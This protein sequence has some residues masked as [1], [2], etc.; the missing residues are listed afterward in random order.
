MGGTPTITDSFYFPR[1]LNDEWKRDGYSEVYA[2]YENEK[3][4]V[5]SVPSS[6]KDNSTLLFKHEITL[7]SR[8]EI[9]DN[10]LFFDAVSKD[11]DMF[12][13]D[14][15]RSNQTSFSFSG[16]I[17]EFVDRINSS[18]AY[19]GVYNP[20]AKEENSKGYH[21][22]IVE[23]YGTDDIKELSF[24]DQYITDV[25]QEIYNTFGLTYYWKGNTCYV[26]KCEN[27]L[28]DENNVIKYG[29]N[30]ALI[31]VNEENTNNK[32][33]DMVT[34]YGSSDNIP[35]YYPNDDEF[36]KAI[37]KTSL[38][39][40]SQVTIALSKLQ[41]NVGGDYAKTYQF[42]KRI[43]DTTG[44]IPITQLNTPFSGASG[45]LVV[46]SGES[47][48]RIKTFVISAKAGTKIHEAEIKT[49]HTTTDNV[50]IKSDTFESYIEVLKKTDNKYEGSRTDWNGKYNGVYECI[51]A[52]LYHVTLRETITVVSKTGKSIS[53]DD[54]INYSYQG[55]LKVD[56]QN[57][58]EYYW[59]YDKGIVEYEDGGIEVI[60]PSTTP[61]AKSVVTFAPKNDP[62]V[63]VYTYYEFSEAIDTTTEAEAAK[64]YI[65]G[66]EWI[67]PTDKLMPSV[68]RNTGGAQR[69]YFATEN[70]SEE[71][72]DIYLNPN[73]NKQYEFKN[74]YKED[75]PHQ[76][77][78]SFEDIKPTIRDIRNDV[79]QADGLGQ[80]FGEIA[81]VAFDS[82]DSDVKDGDGNYIHQY[83]YIKLHK[84]SG[85]F[86]FNLFSSAFEEGAKIE[87]IDC[88]GCPAC[89]FPIKVVWVAAK[90]KCYNCVSVDKDGNLKSLRTE[91]NDYILSD[92]EA[93]L[94]T[95]NQ[96]TMLSEVWIAVQKD[97]STLGIVMPNVNGNF[98][99]KRGDK[100]VITGINSPKVLTL[101][102]EKKLDKAL[103]KYMSE[104][105]EDKFNYSVKFSRIYLAEHPNF[106][107]KLN[108]NAKV[109]LEYNGVRH[110][111]FVNNYSVK[112]DGKIL[113]EVNVELTESVEP[114]Q[115]DIK[116]IV[117]S[118]KNSISFGSP[119]GSNKF[120]ASTTDKLY[121]SK[122]KDDTA[123]GLITFLK[124]LKSQ[125]VIKAINGVSLGNGESHING[126]GDAKLTDVVVD[127]IHDKNSTPSDRVIIG[128]QGFDLYLGDDG[129]SH[130]YV[131]YLTARTRMFASSVEIRK[132][133]Y[134]GGTTIFS[135]AGS[136]IA[137]VS[138]IW[139]AAKEKVIAYKCYA[140]AD[141]GTT[142]TMNWWHVGMMALCQTFNVKAG[143]SEDF[144]NRYYWRMVVGVGQEKIDGKIYDYVILSNVKEFQGNLLTVPSF[145]DKTLANEQSKKLVWGDVMVEITMDKGMQ[146]LASLFM[147]QE[148]T[149]VDDNGN[150]IADR[151]F[152]GYDGE[153]PDAPA[154]FDVIVQVGDQIQWKKYG[155]VIKLSTSTEDNATDNAPAITMYHK[156]GAPH[157]TGSLDANGNK[158]V[159][160]YQWKIITTIISPEKVMHNTD[161]FQLFQG[162]PDNII[163]PITIM[164]DIVPSVAYYTR[165]PST[166]TTTPT[167]ITFSLRKRTGNKV[168]TLTDAQIYA[169]YTLLNGSSATKLL[170]NKALS[171]IGNL[172]QITSVKL[173]STIKEADHEDIVVIY[174]LPVLT[175]GVKGD[176][177]AAGK[178]GTNGRDGVDGKDGINGT[179]GK[180][181]VDGKDGKTPAVVS[182][183]YQYAIT[184]TSAKPADSEWKPVMPDPSKYE[185]KF[186]WT[187][188]TT[189]WSTGDKTDT[190]SCTYIGTDGADGT[191]VT[192][193]GTLGSISELPST[194]TA[195]DGYIIGVFLWIYTGTTTEDSNNHNGYTNV[196]KIKGEDG[197]N[198]TQYYIH[199][200]WMKASDG[201]GFTV[202]NPNGDAYPYV[203]TLV[204]ANEKDS[205]NWRDYKWTYVKGDTGAKGDKGDKGD[206]GLPGVDGAP[207][208]NGKD[209]EDAINIVVKD[210]PMVFDTEDN[211]L[212][213]DGA[214]RYASIFVYHKKENISSQLENVAVYS[215]ENCEC[216]VAYNSVRNCLRAKVYKVAKEDITVDGATTQISKTAGYAT[217]RF[218][219]NGVMYYQQVQFV[220]NVSKFN[221]SVIQTT[222]KYEQKYTEVSNQIDTLSTDVNNLDSNLG[223]LRDNVDSLDQ[224]VAAI[225]LRSAQDLTTFE[226]KI[227][228]TAR[229]ISLSLTEQAVSRRNLLVNSD[230]A[231]NGGFALS[232]PSK[233]TVERLSGYE[234]S[235]CI[236]TFTS[237]TSFPALRWEGYTAKT[238]NIPI[239]GGKKYTISCWVKVS[240]TNAPLYVKVF[241]QKA[242]TGNVE[243]TTAA[244][245]TILDK[246]VPLNS[247]NTWQLVSFT[248]VASGG[249]SYCSVRLFF[250]PPST[251]LIDGYICRPMLEQSDSYNGWTLSE[252]DYNYQ[253]GNMLDNTRY[254]NTGGNLTQV[255]L[256]I[257]NAKDGCSLSEATVQQN[258]SATLVRFDNVS[259]AANTDYVLS[260]F[261]RS[262]FLS[263]KTNV[264]C[265]LNLVTN[266]KFAECSSGSV[267]SYTSANGN[268]TT[269]GYIEL[270][271]IPTEW[272]KVWYH[273]S[274][275]NTVTNQAIAIQMYGRN[276]A[277]TLQVCQ[278]KLEAG[279]MN[280][281]WT[282]ATEDV[283]NK[284]A[285]KRTGI[286]IESGKITL[287]AENTVITGDLHLRGILVENY[288]DLSA[289]NDLF[290]VCDMKAHKSVTVSHS[291]VILPMLDT[292]TIKDHNDKEYTVNG[293]KEAGVKLTIASKYNSY[294]AKW[295]Q[296][297]P[298][299][300]ESYKNFDNRGLMKTY[301]NYASVVFADPRIADKGNYKI[302]SGID[303]LV[304]TILPEGGGGYA[305]TGYEGGVFVCNGRRGRA[306]VLMPG[307]TLH[308][309]SAIE[310]VNEKQVLVWYVD[311]SSDF[312]PLTKEICFYSWD[313]YTY[314]HG[315]RSNGGNAFPMEVSGSSGSEYEDA[316]FG[317]KILDET[318]LNGSLHAYWGG[319][320]TG[321]SD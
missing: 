252:E 320:L 51:E 176:Q 226:S 29:V 106:A 112:R 267:S 142:K 35:F 189:T 69:F 86:G 55:S 8:R 212:V 160:P 158:I 22:E 311:N 155:N 277:G 111:L 113:A 172:Y 60:A 90:N 61:F 263:S 63:T 254:L 309:T 33:I 203:G 197:K 270:G 294:V 295:A 198:A 99:P 74:K 187:K 233:A 154:P 136:Q 306:L 219:Y 206:Q 144:A 181:G 53:V 71:Y 256:L 209:G 265:T 284:D 202:A 149:D 177:G 312:T 49:A 182:T 166:Q 301:H 227:T 163:D 14:K 45:S 214:V 37:Y 138:Y 307:Q 232:T 17:Y 134:S 41:K 64:V 184:A 164:Y 30:D 44:I 34:G 246:V 273:F 257:G 115:N 52:G 116:Q 148:G 319:F 218:S 286:D 292:H 229:N 321:Y 260:F 223:N 175:D 249:Y 82:T 248:F 275:H 20:K 302:V 130:L 191:S 242:I 126:N 205:T 207:G 194:G 220:V 50:T 31:S 24:S 297:T 120:N 235:N 68:Y 66:R 228:Q 308:L 27:D 179:N 241:G 70:P 2:E 317:T 95:L 38:I 161:N 15:Y 42:C 271:N 110:E 19:I 244:T 313:G 239:V 81:D 230:F 132:V 135:N 193:K 195:G 278:P 255:G 129:K 104:N 213:V 62:S 139:D 318:N 185:G 119:G 98:K 84:F 290:I 47:F 258:K 243:T 200:A 240:N 221:S 85:E 94:D 105:N 26:G 285:L 183:T 152:Y 21:V 288:E 211:G 237:S 305:A 210:I 287:D 123:Q 65:S 150:K 10:T 225:P 140:V 128:A 170:P 83:F 122:L 108:E 188:T 269:S 72:R 204:D 76:G 296:T 109:S 48:V 238:N 298:S 208:A 168:E 25:L 169:E 6:T 303:T 88:Q 118:V 5:T 157:Y 289:N 192:I 121:L 56:Y 91:A 102:A 75:N 78:T 23:G 174:D 11:N 180:D 36:G 272:T 151:I 217:I 304:P 231:R 39:E 268:S 57:Q 245:G 127:R 146:T 96:N 162:T 264:V 186:L 274:A 156:L 178:D 147:E 281:P 310:Y 141:D 93:Q 13:V 283:A 54:A 299:L 58:S 251:T 32:I 167:D 291:R 222:K 314:D 279:L 282:E 77:S 276:G 259:V 236:H 1:C 234:G 266:A 87:M 215:T 103:I 117:D 153:K 92:T 199:T 124:G 315:F 46:K 159:N 165:H 107:Q 250:R 80:L 73:T 300:F 247:A 216:E 12:S 79:I 7:V 201:T 261:V 280:T 137:K 100:F 9:L 16:T 190:F 145:A 131:D 67:I 125:D 4:C 253:G 224:Q 293:L 28:T 89:S 3:F 101:A 262:K 40:E 43:G 173:K 59:K 133:S 114:T 97:A 143:E 316:I 171:D 196:G 18:L